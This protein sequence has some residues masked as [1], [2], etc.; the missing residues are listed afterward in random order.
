[1]FRL[2]FDL[3]LINMH[4]CST[5]G[6]PRISK[7]LIL[8]AVGIALTSSFAVT[9]CLAQKDDQIESANDQDSKS[10]TAIESKFLSGVRQLTFEGKRAGEGYYSPS[11][12][13]MVFRANGWKRILSFRSMCSISKRVM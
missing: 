8:A 2:T 1:M 10:A 3:T 11:G 4:R 7:F 5:A 6:I 9:K 12:R 13:Q